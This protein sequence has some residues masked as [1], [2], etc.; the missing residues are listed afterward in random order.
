MNN[1]KIAVFGCWNTGCNKYS[2]Q[3]SVKDLLKLKESDYEFMVILGDNYYANKK[4]YEN[5]D[6]P[7]G[8][9]IKETKL[10]DAKKGFECLDEIKLEK[11]L[12]MGNHDIEDSYDKN[13]SILKNQL[14]LQWYDVKFPY[15]FDIYFVQGENNYSSVLMIYLDTTIYD[16][17]IKEKGGIYCI[18]ETLGKN[19]KDL[20]CE[21]NE[22]IKNTLKFIEIQVYKI[23]SVIFYGHQPLIY[24]KDNNMTEIKKIDPLL[25]LLFDEIT[26]YDNINFYWICADYHVYLNSKIVDQDNGKFIEQWIFGTG[27]GELDELIDKYQMDL[28]LNYGNKTKKIQYQILENNIFDHNNHQVIIKDINQ[29]KL[30]RGASRFGYGEII[31]NIDSITHKFIVSKFCYDSTLKKKNKQNKIKDDSITDEINHK[32]KY[33]KYKNKYLKLKKIYSIKL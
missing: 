11:K 2:G 16:E 10:L 26:K 32:K 15:S 5:I 22:F 13:C 8:L 21:Q 6:L 12:I 25:S 31:L 19:I 30:I 7:K 24:T 9:K 28:I 18:K 17:D 3:E 20:Q 1:F 29:D 14:K 33:L 27:G 4:I 23:K